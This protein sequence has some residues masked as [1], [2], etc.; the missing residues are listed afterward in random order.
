M[1]DQISVTYDISE[2]DL[3]RK[4]NEIFTVVKTLQNDKKKQLEYLEKQVT[5]HICGSGLVNQAII[6]YIRDK[7]ILSEKKLNKLSSYDQ[8]LAIYESINKEI[9]KQ[10]GLFNYLKKNKERLYFHE[11]KMTDKMYIEGY[12]F[13]P[14]LYYINYWLDEILKLENEV[15]KNE[16][17]ENEPELRGIKFSDKKSFLSLLHEIEVNGIINKLSNKYY[18]QTL[19]EKEAYRYVISLF[20][21]AEKLDYLQLTKKDKKGNLSKQWKSITANFHYDTKIKKNNDFTSRKLNKYYK[22]NLI[23]PDNDNSF[24]CSELDLIKN[25]Y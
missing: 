20:V 4:T 21:H 11:I 8:E 12:N 19:T 18:F 1:E 10:N 7:E 17:I 23:N 15:N 14:S 9:A 25:I 24:S 22:E 2:S 16:S 13:A 6:E 5:D 3:S